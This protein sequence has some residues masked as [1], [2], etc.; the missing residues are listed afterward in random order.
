MRPDEIKITTANFIK[1]SLS[2]EPLEIIFGSIAPIV[3][4]GKGTRLKSAK[5]TDNSQAFLRKAADIVPELKGKT[6]R[7]GTINAA[8]NAAKIKTEKKL[9]RPM[10]KIPNVSKRKLHF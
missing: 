10:M 4:G 7:A 8:K 2:K 6:V 1:S 5:P 3:S 9:V